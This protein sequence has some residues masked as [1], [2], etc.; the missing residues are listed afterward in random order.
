[1]PDVAGW[2]IHPVGRKIVEVGGE[3]LDLDDQ[4]LRSPYD[5]LYDKGQNG[6]SATVLL[7][8]GR[9]HQLQPP[10]SGDHV[11]AMAFGPRLTLDAALRRT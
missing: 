5:V 11:V 4:H 1:M 9:L 6:S 2:A 7:V 3:V 10:G 8:L